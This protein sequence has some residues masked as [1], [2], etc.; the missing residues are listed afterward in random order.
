MSRFSRGLSIIITHLIASCRRRDVD[1]W[2]AKATVFLFGSKNE[3]TPCVLPEAMARGIPIIT[4]NVAGIPEQ[5]DHGV[6]G[7]VLALPPEEEAGGGGGGSSRQAEDRFVS[8]MHKLADDSAL[9][10][11]MG[12]AG[13]KR[14]GWQ[15]SSRA[16]VAGCEFPIYPL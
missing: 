5:L 11:S 15:H 14:A 7:F 10:R 12:K 4:S 1:K 8:A 16:M 2:Y 13:I 9:R 6:E 3:V